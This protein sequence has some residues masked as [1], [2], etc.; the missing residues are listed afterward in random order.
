MALANVAYILATN[1]LYG[2]KKVLMIDWDLEAPG[3]YR[4]FGEEFQAKWW[5]GFSKKGDNIVD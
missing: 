1:P 4:Y 2:S 3:L 5:S